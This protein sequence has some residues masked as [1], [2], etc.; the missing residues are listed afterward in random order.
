[1]KKVI[2]IYIYIY[3]NVIKFLQFGE[4][5]WHNHGFYAKLLLYSIGYRFGQSLTDSGTFFLVSKC[6]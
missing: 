2:Y 5:I 4:A 3:I 6:Y 1:M